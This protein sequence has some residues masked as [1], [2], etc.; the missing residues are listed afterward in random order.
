MNEDIDQ[1]SQGDMPSVMRDMLEAWLRDEVDDMLPAIVVKYDEAT[2]RAEI[3]PLVQMGTADNRKVSRGKHVNV[4][5][6]RFGGGGFFI[7][8]PLKTGDFGWLKANDRDIS[9]VLQRGG[10]QDWP[11]TTRKHDF[12]DAMFFPDSLKGWSVSGADVDAMVLQSLDGNAVIAI[13]DDG[14]ELRFGAQVLSLN[15]LG[16]RHNGINVGSTHSHVGS[17]SA[18]DGP[19]TPTGFPLP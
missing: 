14:I 16:L 3:Q 17:P 2:N 19:V 13:G 6:Y 15:A 12:N 4:P 5:V 7:R 18:P 1:S 10:Q 8:M 9:L 11:N